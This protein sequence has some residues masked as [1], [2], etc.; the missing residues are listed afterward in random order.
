[1]KKGIAVFYD[2]HNVYQFLWYYCT[3]G[4]DVK[5][6]ALCLPNSFKGDQ[7]SDYC[8]KLR[9]FET[10]IKSQELFEGWSQWRQ[11]VEFLKMFFYACMGK[12][13]IYAKKFLKKII[14]NVPY[15]KAVVLTDC[16]YVSAMFIA[17]SKEKD[18]IILEDGMGDYLE[19]KYSNI[20]KNYTN[21]YSVKGFILS[22]LG[23]VNFSSR[24]PLRTTKNCVK[25]SSHPEK[26]RYKEY[27][28]IEKLFDMSKTDKE[29]FKSQLEIIY[30]GI[31]NYFINKPEIILF[32][33]PLID[34]TDNSLKYYRKVEDFFNRNGAKNLLIK[35]H[36]R[37]RF[38]YSFDSHIKVEEIPQIIPA[39]V[40][41][42]YLGGIKIF[43]MDFSS[44]NL[45]M[46]SF[47][48]TPKFFYFNDLCNEKSTIGCSEKYAPRDKFIERF[49]F[50]NLK[51]E[52]IID[53]Y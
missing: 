14:G 45:Y 27:K 44:T 3:Y 37:D 31:Q 40:L 21:L 29:L 7:V 38:D 18:V 25:F 6:T 13:T 34:Y 17:M 46:T 53:L 49:S 30:P 51:N 47:H 24:Y 15:D 4:K 2:P 8:S 32:T 20:L 11:F 36:P 1:M 9:L 41:L 48:Y 35:K 12:Q 33:T 42:P 22:F 43:F 50:L 23:Y 52:D 39:E 16:G 10:I 5:W 26:M 28:S 19:R